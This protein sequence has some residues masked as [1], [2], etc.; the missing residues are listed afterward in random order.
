MDK[1]FLSSFSFFFKELWGQWSVSAVHITSQQP[2]NAWTSPGVNSRMHSGCYEKQ[3]M[4]E[5]VWTFKHVVRHLGGC[6]GI[7]GHGEQGVFHQPV[8]SGNFLWFQNAPRDV[9]SSHT[10]YQCSVFSKTSM[11]PSWPLHAADFLGKGK[12]GS[13]TWSLWHHENICEL[14]GE[15]KTH[16]HTHNFQEPGK[17]HWTKNQEMWFSSWLCY[18]KC[19]LKGW[20]DCFTSQPWLI[21]R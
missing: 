12:T 14:E 18:Y 4:Q 19:A 13:Y 8:P 3:C 10:L 1:Y 2:L 9:A 21:R 17:K 15:E 6:R 20:E 5:Q 7:L 16:T 11:V